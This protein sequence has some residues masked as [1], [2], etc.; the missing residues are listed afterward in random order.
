MPT[1]VG[2]LKKSELQLTNVEISESREVDEGDGE[3]VYDHCAMLPNRPINHI[4]DRLSSARA[5][6]LDFYP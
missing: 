6:W 3:C 4:F 5:D 1:C 2:Y